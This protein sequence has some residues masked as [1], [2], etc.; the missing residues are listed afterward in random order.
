[1]GAYDP[2]GRLVWSLAYASPPIGTTLTTS[3]TSGNWSNA[4][5]NQMSAVDLRRVTD[6][7][8]YAVATGVTGTTPSLT[9]KFNVFDDVGNLIN[10]LALTAITAANTPQYATAGQKGFTAATYVALPE[11]GQVAWTITGTTPSFSGV[12]ITVY[13]R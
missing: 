11:W 8:V 13:G 12:E 2:A 4:Q 10:I 1:M 3:G 7:T 6:V 5:P 9:V